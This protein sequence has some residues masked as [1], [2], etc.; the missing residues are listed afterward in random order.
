MDIETAVLIAYPIAFVGNIA[1][2]TGFSVFFESIREREFHI[3]KVCQKVFQIAEFGIKYGN[4]KMQ[5]I[6]TNWDYVKLC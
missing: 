3:A 4:G 2:K 5:V 6:Y 1:A